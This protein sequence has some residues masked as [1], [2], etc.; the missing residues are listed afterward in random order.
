MDSLDY[1]LEAYS[2]AYELETE[3]ELLIVDMMFD[4]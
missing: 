2:S 4:P 1:E 3:W